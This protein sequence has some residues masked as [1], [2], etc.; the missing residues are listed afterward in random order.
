[1][2]NLLSSALKGFEQLGFWQICIAEPGIT[3]FREQAQYYLYR[4]QICGQISMSI[5]SSVMLL[6]QKVIQ[7]KKPF[8]YLFICT[9]ELF[10]YK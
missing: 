9:L 5:S 8:I 6:V 2:Q 4:K 3:S 1:M 7:M 10:K